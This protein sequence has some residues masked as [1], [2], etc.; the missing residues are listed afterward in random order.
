MYT[1]RYI[2]HF[3]ICLNEGEKM[4][5]NYNLIDHNPVLKQKIS[6]L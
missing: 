2:Q 4:R 6:L 3:K 1:F 5:E